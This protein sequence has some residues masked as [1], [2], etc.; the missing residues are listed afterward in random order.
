MSTIFIYE[1]GY[2]NV[3]DDNGGPEPMD[4]IVYQNKFIVETIAIY[5]EYLKTV[6]SNESLTCPMLFLERKG[7]K[8]VGD[9]HR[10]LPYVIP[11]PYIC[12][13]RIPVQ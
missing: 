13:S 1:D 8:G 7:S 6:T 12:L 9:L 3:V 4:Y 2:G 11:N 10:N 5:T